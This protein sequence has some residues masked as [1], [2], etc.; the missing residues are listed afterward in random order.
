MIIDLSESSLIFTIEVSEGV[1][2]RGSDVAERLLG[3]LHQITELFHVN[4]RIL[5]SHDILRCENGDVRNYV[6]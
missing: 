6:I 5:V 3:E 1:E 2:F 4:G